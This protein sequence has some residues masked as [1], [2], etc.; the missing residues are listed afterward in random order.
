MKKSNFLL[1]INNPKSIIGVLISIIAFLWAFWDFNYA[2]F[3]ESIKSINYIYLFIAT[4]LLWSSVWIR[5]F[6]WKLLFEDTKSPS[7]KSLYRSQ[8]IG[9]FGNNILPLRLGEILRTYIVGKEN[10]LPTSFVFGTVVLERF[11]D[12]I[13]LSF[14]SLILF[15]TFPLSELMRKNILL[16]LAIS[17]S[18]IIITVIFL[19]LINRFQINFMF[20]SKLKNLFKGLKSIRMEIVVPIILTSL[21]IWFIYLTDIYLLQKAFGF[22]LEFNEALAILVI[23]SLAIAIP[24]APGM[25]GTFHAAVQTTMVGLLNI[26]SSEANSFAIIMHAYGY[27]LF[28]VIGGY[29]FLQSKFYKQAINVVIYDSKYKQQ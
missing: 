10:S 9:L 1:L 20:L 3:I 22:E 25:V 18:V 21:L 19:S 17:F 7:V 15:Y 27:I 24:S 6:R 29:Y 26:E 12:T 11:L 16:F 23:S 4:I 14:F 28:T 8:M 2:G 5:G 13:S